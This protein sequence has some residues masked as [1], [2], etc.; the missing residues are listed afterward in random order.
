MSAKVQIAQGTH[1][2]EEL[3]AILADYYDISSPSG[4]LKSYKQ[5]LG[6]Y[7]GCSYAVELSDGDSRAVVKLSNGYTPDSAEFMCRTARYLAA[8]GYEDCC[9]PIPKTKKCD[10]YEFVSLNYQPTPAFLLTHVEGQ[11]ADKVMR[12]SPNLAPTVMEGIGSGLGRMHACSSP[13]S[14]ADATDKKLR[15]YEKDGG[16]CDVQDHLEDKCLS[17][18]QAS[19]SP[20]KVSF[21]PIYQ[22]ELAALKKEMAV[23]LEMGITH[24]DPFADNVLVEPDTGKLS[25]FIDIEDVCVGPLLFDLACCAIG[26][27]F[28]MARDTD[29]QHPQVLDFT[30]LEALMKG[31][32]SCRPLPP[33][34]RQHFVAHMRLTLLCNCSWRFCKFH[35][36]NTKED[37]PQ[38]AKDSYLELQRRIEYLHEPEVVAAIEK[39]LE[40]LA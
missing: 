39:V 33:V 28:I 17:K 20:A 3:E 23:E 24:G 2:R 40:K 13:L 21:L 25:A 22:K 12:D 6:G 26:S 16:C 15:Y 5:L 34:E 4:L 27:C 37:V 29:N 19:N 9:L 1:S 31:Y 7:S 10:K 38:E 32:T 11:Q 14:K 8:V 18:I 30:L 35:C 36:N